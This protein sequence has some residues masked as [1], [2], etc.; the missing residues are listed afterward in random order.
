MTA[1]ASLLGMVSIY[2][3]DNFGPGPAMMLPKGVDDTT[4]LHCSLRIFLGH[5][6]V[7]DPNAH[8]MSL[9]QK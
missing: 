3:S 7:H 8:Q 1:A 5:H 2:R 4:T 6:D 9:R